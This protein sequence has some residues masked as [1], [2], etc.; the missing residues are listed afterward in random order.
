MQAPPT[1]LIGYLAEPA[2]EP[3]ARPDAA[4]VLWRWAR[5]APDRLLH[6]KRRRDAARRLSALPTPRT[7]M[8]VCHGNICRSP[9]AGAAFSRAIAASR[10]PG[11]AVPIVVSTA[12]FIGPGRGSPPEALAAA[13]RFGIDLAPHR[14]RLVTAPDIRQADL[15]VVMSVDQARGINAR[16]GA[17]RKPVLVLGDLDPLAI[18]E[19]TILDPWGKGAA[20]FEQSYAR[21]ERCVAELARLIG[22]GLSG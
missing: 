22:E 14:S 12:G 6:P 4:R 18:D 13:S 2:A 9:F 17:E 10:G 15:V 7:V 16:V 3:A 8:F 21:V 5:R 11:G 20:A 19:R 1:T